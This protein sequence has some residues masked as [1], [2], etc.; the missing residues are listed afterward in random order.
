MALL[1]ASASQSP[2]RISSSLTHQQHSNLLSTLYPL[3][4]TALQFQRLLSSTAFHLVIHAYYTAATL[5]TLSAWASWSVAWHA[6][7]TTRLVAAQAW[8]LA[9]R[10]AWAAWDSKRSRRAR[11]RLEHEMFVLLLGPGG[12]T[13]LLMLFWPGWLMLGVLGWGVWLLTG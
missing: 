3:L 13:L 2:P 10:L 1:A 11:K 7:L 9:R 6:L 4:N 5:A 12:N 8:L